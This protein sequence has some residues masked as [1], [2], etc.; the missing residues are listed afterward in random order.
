[1]DSLGDDFLDHR[2]LVGN[3]RTLDDL[4]GIENLLFRVVPLFPFYLV[5]VEHLLVAVLDGSHV[6]NEHVEP[7]FFCQYGCSCAAL[8]GS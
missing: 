4:I 7:F 1:M 5:V 8:C 2:C 3:A 6:G